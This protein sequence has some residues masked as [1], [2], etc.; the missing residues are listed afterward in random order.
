M[1]SLEGFTALNN[2]ILV[3]ALQLFNTVLLAEGDKGWF[4]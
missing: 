1:L 3:M 2:S 4:I